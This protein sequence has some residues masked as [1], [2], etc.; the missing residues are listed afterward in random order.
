[1]TVKLRGERAVFELIQAVVYTAPYHVSEYISGMYN[2]ADDL[3]GKQ[4]PA[5]IYYADELLC[6]W[7]E[8]NNG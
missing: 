8:D 6:R 2:D 7:R 4:E 5:I 1:M 3:I